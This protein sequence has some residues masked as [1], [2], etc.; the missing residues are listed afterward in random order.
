VNK[1]DATIATA[2]QVWDKRPTV[3]AKATPAPKLPEERER[4][5][6]AE[7]NPAAT[8]FVIAT[9]RAARANT[10]LK[11]APVDSPDYR[12]AR[13][14]VKETHAA[15]STAWS[16]WLHLTRRQAQHDTTGAVE[17]LQSAVLAEARKRVTA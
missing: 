17:A 7:L 1:V 13:R 9:D 5:L 4:Q 11:A 16:T 14:L 15:L 3:Q 10:A 2:K 8:A 6:R 12:E